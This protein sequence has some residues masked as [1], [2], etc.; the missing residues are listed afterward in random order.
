MKKWLL[1]N[2][3]RTGADSYT[4][5]PLH[6]LYVG[7]AIKEAKQKVEI[8]DA[9]HDLI[10]NGSVTN[11]EAKTKYENQMIENILSQDFDF[12][13][14]G[15]IVSSYSFSK[16]LVNQVKKERPD[17]PIIVGGNM[18]MPLKNL[19]LE[20]TK[21]DFLAESD[22]EAMIKEFIAADMNYDKLKQIPGLHIRE[23]NRFISQST[24]LPSNLDYISYPDWS[25][26]PNL[27]QYIKILRVWA[28]NALPKE[29]YLEENERI[30]PIVMTRGCPYKCI[31][32]YHLNSKYRK[33]S[34]DYII[35]YLKHIIKEH[36]VTF[37]Q[38]WDDLIMLDLNWLSD[39]C[40]EIA[41]Q[42]IK[43]KFFT[44]GGKPN[45]LTKDVLK[46]MKKAGFMRIS[47]GIESGSQKILNVMKKKTTVEQNFNA[48]KMSTK[49]G[50]YVHLNMVLG[51]PGENLKT[52]W[53][54]FKFLTSLSKEGLISLRNTSFAYATG[55]PGTELYD[56][57]LKNN[58][59]TDTEKYL[60]DQTGVGRYTENLTDT[61]VKAMLF[62][63]QLM[64]LGIE[65]HSVFKNKKSFSS[66]KVIFK[67]LIKLFTSLILP[68]KI[69]IKA[70]GWD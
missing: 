70:K 11:I 28:N 64:Y 37:I 24:S 34:I 39:L 43:L 57:M 68:E 14:L 10:T 60:L 44:S 4:T 36:K 7:T 18:S 48:V 58:F 49:A 65:F 56:H 52:L 29:L 30:F 16:R 51:V 62:M 53:E 50:I 23:K 6:L 1:V 63:Q 31:F 13:G 3:S 21:V 8:F 12:L 19:W 20:Q 38:T 42:K 9:H 54:T 2:P 17:I 45:L 41:A 22:G 47:Y 33:H 5:P 25:L 26:L 32:C 61:S 66:I 40:D 46:K 55:Y 67:R 27:E 15:S 59:V 69:L 35:K